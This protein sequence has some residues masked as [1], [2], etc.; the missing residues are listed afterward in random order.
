MAG[1]D[2]TGRL[3]SG[4]A[5]TVLL[6]GLWL[7]GR[8]A[9]DVPPGL[10]GSAT[11]DMAAAGRPPR[12]ELPPAHRP[13][14]ES[15]PRRLDIPGLGVRA[16]VV[17]GGPGA[18]DALDPPPSGRAG[19]VGWDADGVAPGAS[20]T[21]LL[22]GHGDTATGPAA[23]SGVSTLEAGQ[24]IRVVREDARVAE[25]TVETVRVLG[26]DRSDARQAYEPRRD[27]RAEL[28]LVTCEGTFDEASDRC[29][30]EVIVSAY[31]TATTG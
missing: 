31:L 3:L 28:R 24:R 30:A 15:S 13:L 16:P 4:A 29:T 25:F 9:G 12:L 11:G 5:W 23:L 8:E 7:W 26:R 18:R 19:A 2:G 22:V 21:A 6:L 10:S 20:G 1:R 14:G 17:P 27:G